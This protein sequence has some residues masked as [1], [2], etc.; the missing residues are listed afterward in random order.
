MISPSALKSLRKMP[1]DIA[2]RIGRRITQLE[3][4]PLAGKL[5]VDGSRAVRVGDYRIIY[6]V[7]P[8]EVLAAG[9]RGS[10]YKDY[11]LLCKEA[12]R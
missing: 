6:R 12:R 7:E 3:A 11:G 5:M 8:F 10:V 1:A 2:Q 4:E 9:H